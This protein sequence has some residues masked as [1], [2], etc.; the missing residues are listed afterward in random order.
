MRLPAGRVSAWDIPCAAPPPCSCSV[1]QSGAFTA[2]E[3]LYCCVKSSPDQSGVSVCPHC[4]WGCLSQ[5]QVPGEGRNSSRWW[6]PV[7]V[8]CAG[9]FPGACSVQEEGGW[10]GSRWFVQSRTRE[11]ERVQIPV[12]GTAYSRLVFGM[13]TCMC[14]RQHK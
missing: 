9:S 8:G 3:R 12:S 14:E 7:G 4:P 1:T 13:C 5:M 11:E 10:L 6:E 2:G